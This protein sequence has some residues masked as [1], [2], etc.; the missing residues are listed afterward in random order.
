MQFLQLAF[1]VHEQVF[2][3]LGCIGIE[4]IIA[5]ILAQR[6]VEIDEVAV[7]GRLVPMLDA[8]GQVGA[9]LASMAG[10]HLGRWA[11][12]SWLMRATTGTMFQDWLMG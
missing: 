1:H 9:V 7:D 2:H 6:G 3:D 4:D 5:G 10:V 12:F 8:G 11:D